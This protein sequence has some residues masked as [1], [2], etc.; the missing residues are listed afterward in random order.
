MSPDFE[1]Y[2]RRSG[3]LQ[4]YSI[5][6]FIKS[7][8][9]C[10]LVEADLRL[11]SRPVPTSAFP[12]RTGA[13]LGAP[14]PIGWADDGTCLGAPRLGTFIVCSFKEQTKP[15]LHLVCHG[16]RTPTLVIEKERQP[17]HESCLIFSNGGWSSRRVPRRMDGGLV[18]RQFWSPAVSFWTRTVLT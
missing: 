18:L 7:F 11:G 9:S 5:I 4:D 10:L 2:Q 3:V 1:N 13:S 8:F 17:S 12:V 6:S 15:R 16:R 14:R